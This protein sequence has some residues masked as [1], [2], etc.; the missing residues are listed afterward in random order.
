LYAGG[1]LAWRNTIFPDAPGRRTK[2]GYSV[3]LGLRSMPNRQSSFGTQIE[4][5]WIFVDPQLKP[6]V[7]SL[8]VNFPLW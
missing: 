2:Q 7:F 6:R 8:G 5:R 3:V 1:G 4:L